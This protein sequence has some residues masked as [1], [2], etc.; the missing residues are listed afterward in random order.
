L[1]LQELRTFG[2]AF[3][4]QNLE[5]KGFTCKLFQ[6]NDLAVDGSSSHFRFALCKLFIPL[7]LHFGEGEFVRK[8]LKLNGLLVKY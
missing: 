2:S 1:I 6:N 4:A 7:A 5:N 8:I 3:G